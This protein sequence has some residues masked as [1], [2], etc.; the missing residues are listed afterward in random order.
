M[1]RFAFLLSI[2]L[3]FPGLAALAEEMPD[4]TKRCVITAEKRID[5]VSNLTDGMKLTNFR[6]N[7]G[8]VITVD[9][10]KEIVRGLYLK[11]NEA[12]GPW[13]I[14]VMYGGEWVTAYSA[15]GDGIYHEYVALEGISQPFQILSANDTALPPLMELTLLGEGETPHWV[16]TWKPT[17]KKAALMAIVAHCDDELLFLGGALPLYAGVQGRDTIVVYMCAEDV[18]RRHEALDGLWACGVR[19]QPVF[20]PFRDFRTLTLADAYSKWGKEKSRA[21]VMATLRKYKPDVVLTHDVNGEYGHGA[22]RLT[23]DVVLDC[24]QNGVRENFQPDSYIAWGGWR[25]QKLYLHLYAENQLTMDFDAPLDLFGGRTGREV[26][27]DAFVG[28]HISQRNTIYRASDRGPYN[29]ALW[30]LAYTRVG[31]DEAR[32]D[33]FENV[34]ETPEEPEPVPEP[35]LTPTPVPAPEP[36]VTPEDIVYIF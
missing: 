29:C 7:A 25:P 36:T 20:G 18:L 26:A 5:P 31:Q 16:Q 15:G 33:F 2:L 32:D 14:R 22:H 12:P 21:F 13:E 10:P 27:D 35:V 11:W 9:P 34:E 1:K 3:C 8:T 28:F 6:W 23:A 24:V 30:G 17:P 4:I 19:Q